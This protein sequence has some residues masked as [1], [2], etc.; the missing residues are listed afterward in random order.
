MIPAPFGF[1]EVER[2]LGGAHAALFGE[3][4]FGKAPEGFDAVDVALASG[5]FVF[6]MM[7][8]M[9]FKPIPDQPVLGLPA[10][11]VDGRR[12]L[13]LAVNHS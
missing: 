1:L 13:D 7:H 3:P 11:R 6:M 4:R 2:E 12:A 10:I 5:K 8:S 9:M